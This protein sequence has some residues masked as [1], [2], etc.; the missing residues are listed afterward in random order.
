VRAHGGHCK[1]HLLDILEHVR[2]AVEH[3]VYRGAAFALAVTQVRSGHELRHLVDFLEGEG[4]VDYEG[5]IEDFD[6]AV[7]AITA[8]V[9]TEEVI[10][11][12]L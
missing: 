10:H 5:L 11:E 12:A 2:D 1:E 6:E 9:P 3:G 7:D 8:E 4:V